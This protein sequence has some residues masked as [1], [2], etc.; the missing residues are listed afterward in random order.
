MSR[1]QE[2]TTTP[3][4]AVIQQLLGCHSCGAVKLTSDEFKRI[5]KLYGIV[6]E[7]QEEKPPAPIAPE[8]KNFKDS[9]EY[10]DALARHEKAVNAHAHWESP[11]R[12]LQAGADRN[13]LRHASADGL[14]IVAWL[15]KYLE[16]DQ[17]PLK[18]VIQLASEAGY[19][20]DPED[21][22]WAIEDT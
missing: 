6:Q 21:L 17:D 3:R 9:W 20:V 14:R 22:S 5:R 11:H 16:V 15:A 19:D 4:S 12:L 8:R 2:S 18:L 13:A 7:K 10:K 1:K